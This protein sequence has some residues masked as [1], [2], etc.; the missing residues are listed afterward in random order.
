MDEPTKSTDT[1]A[2]SA[3]DQL[4]SLRTDIFDS[5][6][7]NVQQDEA[8]NPE[9]AFETYL[10]V[11]RESHDFGMIKRAYE[12]AGK[13]QDP[14]LKSDALATLA[15]EVNY[16]INLIEDAT[17]RQSTSTPST[18]E[19]EPSAPSPATTEPAEK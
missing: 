18:A 13:I 9:R 4:Y 11:I 2:A 7:K 6:A 19:N 3:L 16:T 8:A 17:D 1:Q 10:T 14:A 12:V 5:L 15:S